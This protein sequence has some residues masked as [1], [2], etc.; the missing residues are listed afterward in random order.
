GTPIG[1]AHCGLRAVRRDVLPTLDLQSTGM[2]FASEMVIR[3]VQAHLDIREHPIALH[4]RGGE[5]KL[6]PLRDGWRHLRLM[7]VYSPKFLF[8]VPGILSVVLGLLID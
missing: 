4:V 3:A 5:S 8:I 2:E 7:L 6:S 1:D